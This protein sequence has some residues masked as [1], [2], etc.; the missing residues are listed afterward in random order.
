L[1]LTRIGVVGAGKMGTYHCL[2][3]IQMKNVD[4][5]GVFDKD[6]QKAEE[7]CKQLSVRAF[8]SYQGL[9]NSIDAVIIAAPTKFHFSLVEEAIKHQKHIFVEKPFTVSMDEA[10]RLKELLKNKDLIVQVGHVERFNPAVQ[11]LAHCIESEKLMNIEA[12]RLGL[13]NRIQDSDV[14]L[15]VMIH[16]IDIILSLVKSPIN[17]I[18]AEGICV[19]KK[20][21]YDTVTALL[22]FENGVMATLTASN[23]SHEKARTL[24]IVEKDKVI[25]T[26][27]LTRRQ[28]IVKNEAVNF[29]TKLPYGTEAIVIVL[30]IPPLDPL[31]EELNH[32]I[33]CIHTNQTPIV[34]V[35]EGAAAVEVALKIKDILE[36]RG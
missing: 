8:E 19:S 7:I 28:K 35:E 14:V 22:S 16:D 36:K 24:T 18:S 2:K 21:Y 11:Q 33:N 4:F 30:T 5:V 27:Y 15:D 23:V 13:S 1:N 9:L 29:D 26:D 34:G 20:G 32:F 25:K 17:R 12:K 3:L 6:L 31:M 10:N